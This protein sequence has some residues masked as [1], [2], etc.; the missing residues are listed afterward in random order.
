MGVDGLEPSGIHPQYIAALA[1]CFTDGHSNIN[2]GA[3]YF[4]FDVRPLAQIQEQPI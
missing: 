3:G 1:T 4:P 2:K